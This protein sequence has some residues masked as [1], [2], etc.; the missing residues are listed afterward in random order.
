VFRAAPAVARGRTVTYSANDSYFAGKPHLSKFEEL[1]LTSDTAEYNA[2]RAGLVDY[3]YV[4]AEDA[5][6]AIPGYKITPWVQWGINFFT[7][8]Y[9]NPTVGK[10]FDQVYIKQAMAHLVNQPSYIKSILQG[11]GY[12]GYGPCRRNPRARTRRA[13]RRPTRTRTASVP[14]PA[15]SRHMAGR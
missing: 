11:Y 2:L 7:L 1:P 12:A 10:I 9:A 13:S 14:R 3:G 8:N 15:F 4:P 5:S 6:I